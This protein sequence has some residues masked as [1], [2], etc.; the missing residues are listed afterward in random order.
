MP[1]E[2]TVFWPQKKVIEHFNLSF[3]RLSKMR[4]TNAIKIYYQIYDDKRV[5]YNVQEIEEALRQFRE[6]KESGENNEKI[7]S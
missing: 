3:Y 4:E 1:N 7:V 5:Y 2:N 6:V